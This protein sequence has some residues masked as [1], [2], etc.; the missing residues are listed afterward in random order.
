MSTEGKLHDDIWPQ[1][2]GEGQ[3]AGRGLSKP[4][5]KNQFT[6]WHIHIPENDT[7]TRLFTALDSIKHKAS[8][9]TLF[10]SPR[11]KGYKVTSGFLAGRPVLSDL[12][13]AAAMPHL[14]FPHNASLKSKVNVHKIYHHNPIHTSFRTTL[15]FL[16]WTAKMYYSAEYICL[17]GEGQ[18]Q[19]PLFIKV[20]PKQAHS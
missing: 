11:I 14:C 16:T 1:Y 7:Q 2:E 5:S 6:T 18:K 3:E 19:W 12:L 13:D 17:P 9:E 8:A 10:I 15:V 20:S 4:A